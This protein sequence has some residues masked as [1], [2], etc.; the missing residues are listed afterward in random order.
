MQ[1][2]E[3]EQENKKNEGPK[4]ENLSLLWKAARSITKTLDYLGESLGEFLGITTPKYSYEISHF[5]SAQEQRAKEEAF[6][7]ENSWP[8]VERNGNNEPVTQGPS[9]CN[10]RF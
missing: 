1:Y 10:E 5:Q 9:K 8:D 2:S 6:E 4:N 3:D 7:K